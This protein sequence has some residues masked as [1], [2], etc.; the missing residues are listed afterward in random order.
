MARAAGPAHVDLTLTVD[1]TGKIPF[2]LDVDGHTIK[3]TPGKPAP[4]LRLVWPPVTSS[5]TR[6]VLKT[7][8][9]GPGLPAAVQ[10][11]LGI[12]PPA[13][14]RPMTRAAM[15]L[16]SGPCVLRIA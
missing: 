12:V 16:R 3:F 4:P 15:Y 8:G 6:L 14:G 11:A 13:A 9:K 5:P 10:G 1:G 2:E 7:G